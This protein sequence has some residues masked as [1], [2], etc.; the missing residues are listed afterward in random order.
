MLDLISNVA[1]LG[2]EEAMILGISGQRGQS[3][4]ITQVRVDNVP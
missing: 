3:A 1:A 2:G 4:G